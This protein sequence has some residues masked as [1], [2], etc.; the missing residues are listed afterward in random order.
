MQLAHRARSRLGQRCHVAH[1]DEI[2]GAVVEGQ[3]GH[4]AARRLARAGID[5]LEVCGDAIEAIGQVA[6]RLAEQQHAPA[7]RMGLEV[8]G[9]RQIGVRTG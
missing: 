7:L 6:L 1:Q 9:E 2:E 8:N 3:L 5:D 4:L